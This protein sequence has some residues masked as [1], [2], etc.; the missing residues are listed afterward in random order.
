MREDDVVLISDEDIPCAIYAV[1][2]VVERNGIV[3]ALGVI[4]T[5]SLVHKGFGVGGWVCFGDRWL[6]PAGAEDQ[7]VMSD[8]PSVLCLLSVV[9]GR[10]EVD[11][12]HPFAFGSGA[13]DLYPKVVAVAICAERP[14]QVFPDVLWDSGM[15]EDDVVLISDEDIPGAIY[16]SHGVVERNGVIPAHSLVAAD[17]KFDKG[18]GVGGWVGLGSHWLV[19]A[20]TE[21]QAIMP[22]DP[23]VFDLV[24]IICRVE[25]GIVHPFAFGS[26]GYDIGPEIIAGYVGSEGALNLLS[27]DLLDRVS[28]H[29][30]VLVSDEDVPC[31]IYAIHRVVE[32]NGSVPSL[33]VIAADG[34]F[35]K[36][37]GICGWVRFSGPQNTGEPRQLIA[38]QPQLVLDFT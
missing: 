15:R 1:H 6:I 19:P 11:I 16:A 24:L 7:A 8:D 27:S 10:V 30:V 21:D 28:D 17:G 33:G 25:V 34:L 13:C 9:M 29:E 23:S 35:H 5:D 4:A 20:G 26:G 37:F 31:A 2:G 12:V 38:D 22:D 32:R 18:F 14:C 36:G 3:P